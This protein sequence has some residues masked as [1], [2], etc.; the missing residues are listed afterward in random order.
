M[1]NFPIPRCLLTMRLFEDFK[2]EKHQKRL[3][4]NCENA[5]AH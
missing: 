3:N 1:K 5:A 2:S 4:F